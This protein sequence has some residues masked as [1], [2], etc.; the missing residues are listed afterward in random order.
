MTDR[1][2]EETERM[3]IEEARR[4]SGAQGSEPA[5]PSPVSETGVTYLGVDEP[6][7]LDDGERSTGDRSKNDTSA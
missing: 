2:V 5:A 4:R 3:T 6:I 1:D 7:V